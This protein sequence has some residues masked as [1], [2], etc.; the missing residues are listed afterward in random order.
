M[1]RWTLLL[2]F[3]VFACQSSYSSRFQ[4][5]EGGYPEPSRL[6][7]NS[8]GEN[9]Q[10]AAVG[11]LHGAMSCTAVLWS[12]S[13]QSS[14]LAMVLTNGHCVQ[15]FADRATSYETWLLRPAP[16]DWTVTFNIFADTQT[17]QKSYRIKSIL[18]STMNALDLAILQL[19][20]S[21]TQLKEQGLQPIPHAAKS[22]IAGSDIRVLGLPE[23]GFAPREQFLREARCAEETRVSVV[24]WYWHWFDLHRNSCA[25]IGE[26]SSGSAVLNAE[27]QIYALLNTTS[28]GGISESCNRGSPCELHTSGAFTLAN[29]NYAANVVDLPACFDENGS[30]QFKADCPLPS[31]VCHR[32]SDDSCSKIPRPE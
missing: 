28:Q 14:G 6:L 2:L 7:T 10:F 11:R 15:S 5:E 12:P 22:P 17:A 3:F 31:P 4:N 19:D 13:A 21:L 8:Q 30:F 16:A 23:Q 1:H 27:G 9:K 32:A 24:E 18:Y 20:V 26:G 25:D 29:K